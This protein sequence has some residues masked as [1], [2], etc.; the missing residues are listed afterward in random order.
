MYSTTLLIL[1]PFVVQNGKQKL[2]RQQ[3]KTATIKM[4]TSVCNIIVFFVFLIPSFLVSA[5][6]DFVFKDRYSGISEERYGRK[7]VEVDVFDS[8][9]S[10]DS[11][12]NYVYSTLSESYPEANIQ[13]MGNRILKME[14]TSL[15]LSEFEDPLLNAYLDF[16]ITIEARDKREWATE[17]SLGRIETYRTNQPCV[18][19]HAPVVKKVTVYNPYRPKV[20]VTRTDKGEILDFLSS[21]AKIPFLY[22]NIASHFL[23]EINTYI[24]R[25]IW[26][27]LN[28]N[29]YEKNYGQDLSKSKTSRRQ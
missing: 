28:Q 21:S 12:M 16:S 4:K 6:N 2:T 20:K 24:V 22:D 14:A 1:L 13:L 15:G 8:T 9:I 23:S 25:Y 5:Q 26:V 18:R 11:Y 29:F 19:I 10:V 3:D 17:D 7:Y 27:D